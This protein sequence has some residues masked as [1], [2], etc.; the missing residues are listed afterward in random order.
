M[1]EKNIR[2]IE[3][4]PSSDKLAHVETVLP[5]WKGKGKGKVPLEAI[6]SYARLEV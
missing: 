5:Y 6:Q 3:E 2:L 4:I 1:F